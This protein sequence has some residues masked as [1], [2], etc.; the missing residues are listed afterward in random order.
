[1][2]LRGSRALCWE[3]FHPTGYCRRMTELI[4]RRH[5][6]PIVFVVDDVRATQERIVDEL[7]KS[8]YEVV[9]ASS[10]AA[11]LDLL[12]HGLQPDVFLVSLLVDGNAGWDVWRH[13]QT[14]PLLRAVPVAA[15]VSDVDEGAL[16]DA[17]VLK[18]PADPVMVVAAVRR[19]RPPSEPA[20]PDG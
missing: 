1:M 20:T 14:N 18:A 13:R 3:S 9:A 19:A 7:W 11:A 8:G 10:S 17:V 6:K 15:I 4:G 12:H 16:G 5:E 2:P